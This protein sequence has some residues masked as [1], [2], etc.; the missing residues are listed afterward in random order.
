MDNLS[1]SNATTDNVLIMDTEDQGTWYILLSDTL[2][3]WH[4]AL[5][6]VEGIQGVLI[7]LCNS[8]VL[9]LIAQERGPLIAKPSNLHIVS[10]II[11]DIFQGLINVPTVMY[12]SNGVTVS[13]PN[14]F[15]VLF[16]ATTFAFTQ[17]FIIMAMT[18]D[19]YWAIVHPLHYKRHMTPKK[20]KSKQGVSDC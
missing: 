10:M 9:G 5:S 18:V 4:L 7:V 1:L 12:L 16:V 19:R 6:V 20:T 2:K 14:C 8:F 11:S 17:I 3:N 15:P 13:H